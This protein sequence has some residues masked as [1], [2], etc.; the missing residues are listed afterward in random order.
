[1]K[2][3]YVGLGHAHT[4]AIAVQQAMQS[5]TKPNV[6]LIFS[7][8]KLN[9]NEIYQTVRQAVGPNCAIIGGSTS[10]EFSS[11]PN[12]PQH[13][14]VVIMTLQ[15]SYMSIG[16]GVG[17]HMPQNP[18]SAG[19]QA[20]KNAYSSIVT[21]PTVTSM[22][23]IAMS[24]KK[25]AEVAHLKPFVSLVLPDGMS[26]GE[27]A[28]LRSILTETGKVGQIVGGS[29]GNDLTSTI[30][31]QYANGVYHNAGVMTLITS[32]LKMGTGMGHPYFPTEQGMVVTKGE[33]RVVYELNHRPAADAM[34]ELLGVQAL[35]PEIFAANPMGVKSADVFGQ[36]TIKSVM[37]ENPDKSL[38]FY[39]EVPKGA[40][41]IRM[42]TNRDYAIQSF[43][44]VLKDAV[45][46]AG[47]P[48]K[49]GAVIVFNCIL[50]YLL[51]CRLDINDLAIHREVFG[52]DVPM[53][54]FNTF[55]EQGTTL[56]GSLGHYN[57][58]ATV[59]VIA[60]E[61]ITQ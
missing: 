36:Y 31:Y 51:K 59:L 1:M 40:Y 11:I 6:A 37:L 46:D 43:R 27:E 33:G 22:M 16:V 54:G 44:K 20:A 3:L 32:A 49:I 9:P 23:T 61:T 34:K 41:L 12:A 50:R 38:T 56:G 26:G 30:S 52:P 14:S 4:A 35:T 5:T 10:G 47:S 60:D 21:S 58:T 2:V 28:F 25:S 8:S 24:N 29:T 39:A 7:A 45:I 19:Q 55:G 17:T 18:E 42:E 15:S 13:A 48:K 57:Q 53:I